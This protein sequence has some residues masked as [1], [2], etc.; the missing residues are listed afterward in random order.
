MF[1]EQKSLGERLTLRCQIHQNRTTQVKEADDFNSCP[2]GG[3]DGVCGLI[4]NCGHNCQMVCHI[5]NRD[6]Q[7]YRCKQP[8][9][10]YVQHFLSILSCSEAQHFIFNLD[11][12]CGKAK[13]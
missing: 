12:V 3:C 8:C 10:K 13:K 11:K 2:E 9:S 7:D 4:L 5:Q 1:V 6:H